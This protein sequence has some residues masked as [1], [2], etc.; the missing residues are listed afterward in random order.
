MDDLNSETR[1]VEVAMDTVV[2]HTLAEFNSLHTWKASIGIADNLPV[3][4]YGFTVK[5]NTIV[6]G[7]TTDIKTIQI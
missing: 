6:A 3:E 2:K 1:K 4:V 7:T 5:P